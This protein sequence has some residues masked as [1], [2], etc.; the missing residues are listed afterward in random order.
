ME[1]ALRVRL[2]GWRA[3]S[4][5]VSCPLGLIYFVVRTASLREARELLTESA[6]LAVLLSLSS[7]ECPFSMS[8]DD[9]LIGG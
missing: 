1:L 4:K 6:G 7:L 3:V 2:L 8:M 5:C 9:G